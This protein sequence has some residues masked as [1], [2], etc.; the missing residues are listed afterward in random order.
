[1]INNLAEFKTKHYLNYQDLSYILG[2]PIHIVKKIENYTNHDDEFIY[3]L[4]QLDKVIDRYKE[5]KGIFTHIDADLA[6]RAIEELQNE[7]DT[8]RGTLQKYHNHAPNIDSYG[9][10]V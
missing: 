5:N 1:L 3:M 2:K 4:R 6:G 8:L 9:F 10:T 7:V